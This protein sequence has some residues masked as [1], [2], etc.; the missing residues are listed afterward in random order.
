MAKRHFRVPRFLRSFNRIFFQGFSE[1]LYMI[2]FLFLRSLL[3]IF[4]DRRPS[5]VSLWLE[6]TSED[7]DFWDSW[8]HS[9]VSSL[10]GF[11]L[12]K[13]SE[14]YFFDLQRS[15]LASRLFLVDRSS[16]VE[17]FNNKEYFFS[18][19][20]QLYLKSVFIWKTEDFSS[21]LRL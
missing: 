20:Q 3:N 19:L 7:L 6:D 11:F 12:E 10:K 1:V 2:G 9:V 21:F 14:K 18:H 15:L 5:D 17:L 4:L 16:M 13:T 8:I